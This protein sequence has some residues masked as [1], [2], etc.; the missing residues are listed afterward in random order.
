MS[1][2]KVSILTTCYNRAL[3]L[4]DAITSVLAQTFED[5]EYI[6]V[7]DGSTDESIEIATHYAK[8]DQ[9]IKVYENEGNLGD[10][11]NRNRAASYA[12]GEYIKY[13]DIGPH[14]AANFSHAI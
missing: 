12:T 1:Q 8:T 14:C 5:F 6:I 7:D 4:G 10:Y 9:R 13:I 11:P 2:P 3:F